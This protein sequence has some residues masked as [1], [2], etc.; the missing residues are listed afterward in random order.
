M[1]S[2]DSLAKVE[3]Y[4]LY[5]IDCGVWTIV[6]IEGDEYQNVHTYRPGKIPNR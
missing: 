2:Y 6:G 3:V 4:D 1:I 5:H